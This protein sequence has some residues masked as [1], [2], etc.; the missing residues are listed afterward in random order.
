VKPFNA[1]YAGW[2][3]LSAISEGN[4]RWLIGL[5]TR[6][7]SQADLKRL[8]VP[9]PRQTEGV[10]WNCQ[11]YSEMLQSLASEQ[12]HSIKTSAS[13]FQV[14]EK[15]GDYFHDRLVTADFVEDPPLSFIVDND[16]DDD[17]ENALRIAM[18][19]GAIVCFESPATVGGYRSLRGKRFRLTYLLAPIFKLPMRKSKPV[20]LSAILNPPPVERKSEAKVDQPPPE[21]SGAW[22]QDGLF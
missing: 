22:K 9:V 12:F 13:V 15:I 7:L 19:H 2:E 10:L 16:V 6:I 18:N 3:S 14:L 17:V 1:T 4:P 20:S 8:P 21:Q 5:I 11:R